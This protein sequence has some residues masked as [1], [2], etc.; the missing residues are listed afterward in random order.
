MNVFYFFKIIIELFA[1][2]WKI[3]VNLFYQSN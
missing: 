3:T 2:N 1:T